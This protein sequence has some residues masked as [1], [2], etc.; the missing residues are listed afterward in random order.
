MAEGGL[1]LIGQPIA[2][3]AKPGI[4]AGQ[5][6]GPVTSQV[7]A[8]GRGHADADRVADLGGDVAEVPPEGG[9]AQP[10][11]ACQGEHAGFSAAGDLLGSDAAAGLLA[12]LDASASA[13]RAASLDRECVTP[14]GPVPAAGRHPART[15]ARL[16]ASPRRG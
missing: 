5:S 13:W 14:L 4:L 1:E 16:E 8:A 11:A 3:A 9:V 7:L 15:P 2:V 6:P 12:L 10:E